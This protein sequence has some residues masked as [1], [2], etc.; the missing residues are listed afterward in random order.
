MNRYN[1]NQG[2]PF[3][4]NGNDNQG[5]SFMNNGNDNQGAPFMNNDVNA[6]YSSN[7][8]YN[9]NSGVDAFSNG[10]MN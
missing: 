1:D 8:S 3:M 9:N 5:T 2:T 10:D 4:N 6:G 7:Y